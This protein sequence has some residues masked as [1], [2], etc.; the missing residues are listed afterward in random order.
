[1]LAEWV[2]LDGRI[3]KIRRRGFFG[4]GPTLREAVDRGL[5]LKRP[6]DV[7]SVDQNA[8]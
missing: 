7:R 8:D 5:P 1:M 3:A 2:G 6:K 4:I